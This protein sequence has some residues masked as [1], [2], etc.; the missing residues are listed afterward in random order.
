[1]K[2]TRIHKIINLYYAVLAIVFVAYIVTTL[3]QL[4][5]TISYQHQI[6]ALQERQRQLSIQQEQVELELADANSLA[7]IQAQVE[8]EYKPISSVIVI[9]A[10]QT[11]ALSL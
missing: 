2:K 10:D 4:S 5:Q 8:Q 6:S 9:E 11:L 7:R 1:M 3:F